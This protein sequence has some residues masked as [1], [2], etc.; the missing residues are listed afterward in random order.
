MTG[1]LRVVKAGLQTTL[2][3]RPFSGYRNIGM[4]AAGAADSLSLA[5]AN[6]LVGN[7]CDQIALE[8][9]LEEAEFSAEASLNIALVG[10]ARFLRINGQDCNLHCSIQVNAGDRIHIGA[11]SSGCRSYLAI[12]GILD[13]QGLLGGH[14]TYMPAALGGFEGRALAS[15]D[16]LTFS[17]S[18]IPNQD[19]QKTPLPLRPVLT[20]QSLIRI[21]KGPEFV[22]LG[23]DSQAALI[24]NQWSVSPRFNRMGLMLDG[25][26]LETCG[27]GQMSS[28]PVFAGTI[29]CPPDGQPFLLGPDAQTTGGY[30]RIAQVIRADRHLVGQLK[31]GSKV[32]FVATTPERATDIYREKLALLDPWLGPVGLW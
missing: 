4:P 6:R 7:E 14:S 17:R 26:Q 8:I 3:G 18:S 22:N 24:E 28:A 29:Q 30:P 9:A 2:Q 11:A 20:D 27:A 16:L 21:I 23:P 31:A 1:A 13:A 10:S 5:L 19:G 32:R 15:G 25:K 12:S